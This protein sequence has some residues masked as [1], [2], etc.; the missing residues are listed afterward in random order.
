MGPEIFASESA[1]PESAEKRDLLE[2]ALRELYFIDNPGAQKNE[3]AAQKNAQEYAARNVDSVWVYYPWRSLALR[4]PT[5]EAYLKLRTARN[6]DLITEDEQRK[7]RASHLGIAGLSVGSSALIAIALTG[8]PK[9][10]K[11]ADPDTIEMSNLNRMQASLP[12]VGAKKTEVLA[13]TIWER[14][15]FAQLELWRD[16]L[17]RVKLDAFVENLDIFVDE[18]D[19]IGLKFAAREACRNKAIPVVMATDN[20]DGAILDVERFD[21]EPSRPLFHGRVEMPAEPLEK[22]DRARF[23]ELANRIIDT[24]YFTERQ[25]ASVGRVGKDLAG[26]PQLGSAA[27]L[28][29]AIAASAVR[30]ISTG[31]PLP[32]GR[33]RVGYEQ[34]LQAGPS[35]HTIS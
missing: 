24:S 30:A 31:A 9:H 1:V 29:G 8:G 35:L 20:G 6:R 18:M 2:G 10:V 16:G 34:M 33:Y 27:M 4:V 13:Q 23:V 21:E 22:L 15:P 5:E 25:L 3:A 26:V 14:D 12:D 7:Y 11:L 17:S 32:S 19:D 28:S